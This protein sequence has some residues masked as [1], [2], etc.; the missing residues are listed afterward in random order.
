MFHCRVYLILHHSVVLIKYYIYILYIILLRSRHY[1]RYYIKQ[2]KVH[3][4]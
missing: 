4:E 2:V 1:D 3:T